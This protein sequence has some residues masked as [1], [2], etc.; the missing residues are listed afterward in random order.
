MGWLERMGRVLR[1]QMNSLVNEAEDPEKILEKAVMDMEQ[2]LIEMRRA[3]AEAIATQ[4]STERYIANYQQASQK[5]YERAQ[6]ALEKGNEALAKEALLQRQSYQKQAQSLQAQLEEQGEVIGKL[7]KDLRTLEHKYTEAKAKKNLYIAR[8]RSAMATQKIHEITS[9]LNS[10]SSVSVFE[11]IET[12]ILEL[13]ARS[14]LTSASVTD[15]LEE[16]FASLEDGDNVDN[17]NSKHQ[18]S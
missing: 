10:A 2:K 6:I 15:S 1:A 4:K 14:Q 9:N 13:E 3:L 17:A 7:K 8:L 11:Q 18:T 12:K 5:W 16:K